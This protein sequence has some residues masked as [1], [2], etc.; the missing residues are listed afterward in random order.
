MSASAARGAPFA[1]RG[2]GVAEPWLSASSLLSADAGDDLCATRGV[3]SS[4]KVGKPPSAPLNCGARF[5]GDGGC[6][7]IHGDG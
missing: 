3:G 7:I 2:R 4:K 5:A 1:S 6:A